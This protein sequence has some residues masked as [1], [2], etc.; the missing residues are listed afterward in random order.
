MQS[1]LVPLNTMVAWDIETY[2]YQVLQQPHDNH[3]AIDRIHQSS[4]FWFF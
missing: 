4:E 2:M 3:V 1:W